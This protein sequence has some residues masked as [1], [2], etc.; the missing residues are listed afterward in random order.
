MESLYFQHRIVVSR[1]F[2]SRGHWSNYYG[3]KWHSYKLKKI[4]YMQ[5]NIPTFEDIKKNI[6]GDSSGH[7]IY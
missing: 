3:F 4:L 5:Q 1:H 6:T 7:F 2:M